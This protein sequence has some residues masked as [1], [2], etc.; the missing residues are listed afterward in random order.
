MSGDFGI[1]SL[2][3]VGSLVLVLGVILFIFYL[4][5]RLR[6]GQFTQSRLPDMRLLGTLNLAPK[7]AVSLVE[8]CDEWFILGVGTESVTLI[9]KM[10]RPPKS[11]NH[12]NI[13]RDRGTTFHSLL[14][15]F[16]SRPNKHPN[17]GLTR[18]D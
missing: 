5:K 16:R 2:K 8:I 4:I 6:I 9:S 17:G 18:N 13:S 15:N 7:R 12:N 11:D 10:D 14:Q 3:M 1:E